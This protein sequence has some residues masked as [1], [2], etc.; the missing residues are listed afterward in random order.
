MTL[1]M[2]AVILTACDIVAIRRGK[3]EATEALDFLNWLDNEKLLTLGM[4]TDYGDPTLQ[5]IRFFDDP[6]YDIARMARE[7]DSWR[8]KQDYMCLQG[9]CVHQGFAA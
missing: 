9:S 4:M 7:I 1:F 3:V 2:D 6:N 5:L 8:L